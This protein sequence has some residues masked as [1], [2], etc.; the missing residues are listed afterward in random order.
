M[1]GPAVFLLDDLDVIR[2]TLMSLPG[3]RF[4]PR[5]QLKNKNV[6]M[7]VRASYRYST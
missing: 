5:L 6:T 1:L 2:G 4:L 3:V 7:Y